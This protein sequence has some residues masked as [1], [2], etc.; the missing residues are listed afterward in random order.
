MNA[1][2][3]NNHFKTTSTTEIKKK[4]ASIHTSDSFIVIPNDFKV[5]SDD[6]PLVSYLISNFKHF[7]F[8]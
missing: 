6:Y 7:Y 2:T 3:Q 1:R 5:S 4:N 8:F